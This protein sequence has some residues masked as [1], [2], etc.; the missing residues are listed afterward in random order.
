MASSLTLLVAG[1]RAWESRPVGR[2]STEGWLGGGPLA[3]P[4]GGA[5]GKKGAAGPWGG[6]CASC[7]PLS[8]LPSFSSVPY[9]VAVDSTLPAA[10]GRGGGGRGGRD[11]FIS[12]AQ[13]LWSWTGSQRQNKFRIVSVQCGSACDGCVCTLGVRGPGCVCRCG[14]VAVC[15]PRGGFVPGLLEVC[16]RGVQMCVIRTMYTTAGH[17]PVWGV[18]SCSR[19]MCTCADLAV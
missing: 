15:D 6:L 5:K 10:R 1:T 4:W 12:R 7:H 17:V 18:G 11:V 2:A 14:S 3:S 9:R 8:L 19:G 16:T 13:L